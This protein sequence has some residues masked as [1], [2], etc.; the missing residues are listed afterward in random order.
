[1]TVSSEVCKAVQALSD[2]RGNLQSVVLNG[3]FLYG[4]A[5]FPFSLY[6]SYGNFSSVR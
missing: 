4:Y 6:G 5:L 2:Q 3:K 1:M